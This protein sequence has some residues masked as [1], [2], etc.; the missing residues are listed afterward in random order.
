MSFFDHHKLNTH[1]SVRKDQNQQ[2][3][4]LISSGINIMTIMVCVHM[5]F[6]YI[7]IKLISVFKVLST[8]ICWLNPLQEPNEFKHFVLYKMAER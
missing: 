6:S 4:V 7:K 1:N 5:E 2:L 3:R 8:F